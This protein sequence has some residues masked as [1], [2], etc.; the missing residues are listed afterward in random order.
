MHFKSLSARARRSVARLEFGPVLLLFPALRHLVCL[1][2]D[3]DKLLEGCDSSV[4]TRFYAMVNNL[5]TTVSILTNML[6]LF[7]SS[8]YDYSVWQGAWRFRRV[9][10][11]RICSSIAQGRHG[12]WNDKQCC[13]FSRTTDRPVWH[14]WSAPC[15]GPKLFQRIGAHSALAE[16]AKKQSFARALHQ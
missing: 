15:P 12:L 8:W 3:C 2:G 11:F 1:K 7:F 5:H 16:T 13:P 6:Y 9:G 14:R 4:R 10:P